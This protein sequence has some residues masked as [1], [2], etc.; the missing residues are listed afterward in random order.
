[1]T[2]A[3]WI[4]SAALLAMDITIGVTLVLGLAAVVAL[5]VLHGAPAAAR[6]LTW[7]CALSAAV[8]LPL[9]ALAAPE[10]R[11]EV[12]APLA[13]AARPEPK[14]VSATGPL[15]EAAPTVR[16]TPVRSAPR[17]AR[18]SAALAAPP[19]PA[20]QTAAPASGLPSA[21]APSPN[22]VLPMALLLVWGM[23][24]L[25]VLIRFGARLQ[26]L[27]R[28]A[29]RCVPYPDAAAIQILD[30]A[31]A[32][33]AAPEGIHLLQAPADH[34]P[35]GP[36][37][38]GLQRPVVV[39]PP[40]ALLWPPARM[41]SVLLHEVAHVRRRD[42][43][44]YLLANVACAVYWFH[45][46]VWWAAARLR[47]ESELACDDQVLRAGIPATEYAH[48]LVEII[49]ALRG[50]SGGLK[51]AISMAQ[52]P[53]IEQRLRAILDPRR[54]RGNLSPA[55]F[56]VAVVLSTAVAV[57]AAGVRVRPAVDGSEA[58]SLSTSVSGAVS[59]LAIR[60]A[61]VAW[62]EPVGGLRAGL[63]W[64]SADRE[65]QPGEI[66]A[67]RV[68]V[69]NTGTKPV[70]L[71]CL[72]PSTWDARLDSTGRVTL[73]PMLQ[74]GGAVPA[75]AIWLA[76][77]KECF[78]PGAGPRLRIAPDGSGPADPGAP[79]ALPAGS[80]QV[81]AARPL[82][83][84][85]V[86]ASAGSLFTG[87]LPLQ[88]AGGSAA[89]G[90]TQPGAALTHRV[91]PAGSTGVGPEVRPNT[92]RPVA[93]G[94]AP[95][96]P[97]RPAGAVAD[98]TKARQR[99]QQVRARVIQL[100]QQIA[101]VEDEIADLKAKQANSTASVLMHRLEERIAETEE[102]IIVAESKVG[103]GSVPAQ[104]HDLKQLQKSLEER[105]ARARGEVQA[106]GEQA[107]E[108]RRKRQDRLL[109]LKL[110]LAEAEDELAAFGKPA[111]PQSMRPKPVRSPDQVHQ[112]HL[113]DIESELL[114]AE[115]QLSELGTQY[116]NEHPRMRTLRNRV[117]FLQRQRAFLQAYKGPSEGSALAAGIAV[118]EERLRQLRTEG[119]GDT[120]EARQTRD[121]L[122]RLRKQ[123]AVRNQAQPP[124]SSLAAQEAAINAKLE[125][126]R[127]K[128]AAL[129]VEFQTAK[130]RGAADAELD[131]LKKEHVQLQKKHDELA[132]RLMET[133]KAR[134]EHTR[135]GK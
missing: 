80:Y 4:G 61:A 53:Q 58:A 77:G 133:L 43:A 107:A 84:Q 73:T 122:M 93:T 99:Q 16:V 51:V 88:V 68:R 75:A 56:T 101:E 94:A 109:M 63:E 90:V 54:R 18:A 97:A 2:G 22:R 62:G 104:V 26:S 113:A 91:S 72:K 117:A 132:K 32:R 3:S 27:H 92:V 1:M 108:E 6:H 44:G 86:S 96:T 127:R 114:A 106:R 33:L 31:A 82:M 60:N 9:V 103:A 105:L 134:L 37:T 81:V 5:I 69:R 52:G 19:R 14:P 20:P 89:A 41:R 95:A 87:R 59:P 49:K 35:T 128:I 121:E 85:G 100:Q 12:R 24:M 55:A 102:Q 38:W 42:W 110:K 79:L 66:L 45:P 111:S 7:L 115:A 57:P 15:A 10:W 112:E 40:G 36:M 48:A 11:W 34:L 67:L 8:V 131:V 65:V 130:A 70:R 64:V 47:A 39:L 50:P 46:L 124:S 126:L 78:V 17:P 21:P 119:S 23:G 76:P 125:P 83:L 28:F 74:G 120:E 98:P 29:A 30:A 71:S 129:D 118:A 123:L 135:R 13:A 116:G 25:L